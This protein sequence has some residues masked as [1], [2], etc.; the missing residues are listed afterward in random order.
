MA[1]RRVSARSCTREGLQG[2]TGPVG[3]VQGRPR[4]PNTICLGDGPNT[5]CH[6]AA[7]CFWGGIPHWD[8]ARAG[9][10]VPRYS[11]PYTHPVYPSRPH[12]AMPG[13][14]RACTGTPPDTART[15][16]FDTRV[17]EPRGIE[18]TAVS[19]SQ[20]GL[21]WLYCFTR[22]FDWVLDCFSHCF[23]EF[24]HCFTEFSVCFT[25]FSLR[26]TSD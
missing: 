25:E 21:Y 15:C 7:S 9:W 22:P 14:V 19:G 3:W 6:P 20:A 11:P 10:V 16:R 5:P 26:L 8:L 18:H 23:T 1:Q 12:H 13:R 24:S 2:P 4:P 17:G